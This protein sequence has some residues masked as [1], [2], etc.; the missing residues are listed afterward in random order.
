M[1]DFY[2]K[3]CE[4]FYEKYPYIYDWFMASKKRV[5]GLKAFKFVSTAIMYAAYILLLA[6]LGV[7]GDMRI[8]RAVVV[9]AFV[10]LFVT[11]VRKGINARRPYEK[12]PIKPVIP[13]STKGKSC[14]SRHTACAFIIALAVLYVSVPFGICLLIL[15][16][17]IGISRPVMGVHFPLD[18]TF[19]A[20]IAVVLGIVGFYIIP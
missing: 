1:T 6:F 20:V 15:S 17:F 16:V 18:V 14:P 10:F 3:S 4:R 5:S 2:N 11:A 12:Y 19:A 9:P 13:K 7:S 8:I